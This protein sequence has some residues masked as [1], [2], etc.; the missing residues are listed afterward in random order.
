MGGGSNQNQRRQKIQQTKS[1]WGFMKFENTSG[2]P[3][4]IKLYQSHGTHG[5][6]INLLAYPLGLTITHK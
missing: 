6:D 2:N 1:M 4:D 5:H 3:H